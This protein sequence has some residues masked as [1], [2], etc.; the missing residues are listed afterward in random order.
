VTSA[1]STQS[2][3]RND[4]DS[5]VA[6]VLVAR[7]QTQLASQRQD[8]PTAPASLASPPGSALPNDFPITSD[9]AP[10]L[11]V[12]SEVP[13][14]EASA[15]A[16][17]LAAI[18]KDSL[19]PAE[20]PGVPSSATL[21]AASPTGAGAA[22]ASLG[23]PVQAA[24]TQMHAGTN[25]KGAITGKSTA[26]PTSLGQA[27][28]LEELGPLELFPGGGDADDISIP[29]LCMDSPDSADDPLG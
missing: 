2:D 14:E 10:S 19:R 6:P 23:A 9:V 15:A 28:L 16:A 11:P 5:S 1:V 4:Q 18:L 27:A 3:N 13:S 25:E 17:P 7:E 12:A 21:D 24:V 8:A 22:E 29:E 20:Q 26:L